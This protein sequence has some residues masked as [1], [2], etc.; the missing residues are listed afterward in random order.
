MKIFRIDCDGVI[1]HVSGSDEKQAVDHLVI[2]EMQWC[3]HLEV[4][5]DKW[6]ITEVTEPFE[7]TYDEADEDGAI[8]IMSDELIKGAT[9]PDV[10]CCSEW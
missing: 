2:C 8:S 10:L 3:G 4:P 7:I 1:Y 9:R 6:V 5:V